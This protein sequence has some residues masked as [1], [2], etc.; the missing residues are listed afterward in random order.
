MT[1]DEMQAAID[2]AVDKATKGLKDKVSELHSVNKALKDEAQAAKDAAEQA[3]HDAAEKST[4]VE[5]VKRSYDAKLKKLQADL[6]ASTATVKTMLIDNAIATKIGEAGVFPHFTRA[7]TAMLKADAIVKNGEA[8]VGDVPLSDY[9]SGFLV[10]DEGK[11][12][13]AAPQNGGAGATGSTAKS[14]EWS[15]APATAV[16]MTAW[17]NYATANPT[18]ANSLADQWGMPHLKP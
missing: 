5:D 13:V 3:E 8:M 14:S 15:K 4:N 16:E 10:S 9:I 6:D 7:V 1:D 11:H 17:A 18:S 2:A 12:F